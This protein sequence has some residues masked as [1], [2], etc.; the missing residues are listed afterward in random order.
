MV[1]VQKVQCNVSERSHACACSMLTYLHI[2][3]SGAAREA[4]DRCMVAEAELSE[5]Q[6]VHKDL[7]N[8]AAIAQGEVKEIQVCST[9]CN[10]HVRLSTISTIFM[11]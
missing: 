3:Q 1:L 7:T 9:L 6:G 5:L 10:G 8:E 11:Q 2:I 4:L